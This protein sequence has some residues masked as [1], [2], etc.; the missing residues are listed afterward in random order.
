MYSY[1]VMKINKFGFILFIHFEFSVKNQSL[2][3]STLHAFD[4]M[5]KIV[6]PMTAYK[7]LLKQAMTT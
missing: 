5:S 1:T 2:D 7:S 3:Y 6:Q 4:V